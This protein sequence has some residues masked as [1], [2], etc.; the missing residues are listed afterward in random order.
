MII[1]DVYIYQA[2][3]T[4]SSVS[5]DNT[6]KDVV[7]VYVLKDDS[8]KSIKDAADYNFG[9]M[10][11]LIRRRRRYSKEH[12]GRQVGKTIKTQTYDDFY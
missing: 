12:Y 1:G 2:K 7:S 5:G 4:L 3:G 11:Y 9:I 8:A 10:Q 6:K